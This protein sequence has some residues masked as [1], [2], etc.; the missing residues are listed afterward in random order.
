[1]KFSVAKWFLQE[2]FL[3]DLA[4]LEV[5]LCGTSLVAA[6]LR[7]GCVFLGCTLGFSRAPLGCQDRLWQTH[8]WFIIIYVLWLGFTADLD[9]L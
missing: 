6:S 4:L 9:I 8:S 1:M 7:L 2:V 3:L 5:L